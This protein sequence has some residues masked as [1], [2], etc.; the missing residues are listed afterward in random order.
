[1]TP[2][3]DARLLLA[4]NQADELV[5]LSEEG[6]RSGYEA[7]AFLLGE[8]S[9]RGWRVAEVHPVRNAAA[10]G[11]CFSVPLYEISRT[12]VYAANRGLD[13]V[14][15]VHTHPS[16]SPMLSVS[17]LMACRASSWL[18]VV[19]ASSPPLPIVAAYRRGHRIAVDGLGAGF[20]A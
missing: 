14:G 12:R 16:G 3:R 6:R 13:L 11:A 1:M 7:C 20:A 15:F 17:D 18:W 9:V 2:A 4:F 5:T 19:V 8:T 10:F